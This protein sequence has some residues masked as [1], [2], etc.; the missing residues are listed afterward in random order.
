MLSFVVFVLFCRFVCC[1]LSGYLCFCRP[2]CLCFCCPCACVFA[3]RALVF[4][5]PVR[6]Y[7]CCPCACIFAAR[8][9]SPICIILFL[10][11]PFATRTGAQ[12]TFLFPFARLPSVF[13]LHGYLPFSVC[14][15]TFRFPFARLPSVFRLHGYLPF[16][17]AAV[18]LLLLRCRRAREPHQLKKD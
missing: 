15:A 4:L 11:H 3:V 17:V 18:G 7:F 9:L 13:R 14:T 5:L 8:V 10:S 1:F 2:F 16:A 12:I 6:L